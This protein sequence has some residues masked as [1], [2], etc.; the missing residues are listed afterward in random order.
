VNPCMIRGTGVP[1]YCGVNPRYWD[2][3]PGFV[4]NVS[5]SRGFGV[6]GTWP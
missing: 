5:G 2:G 6:C 4:T 1:D 3:F